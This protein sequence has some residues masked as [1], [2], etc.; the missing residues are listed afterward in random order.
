MGSKT[1]IGLV[2][3]FVASA[4]AALAAPVTKPDIAHTD[5]GHLSIQGPAYVGTTPGRPFLFLVP[6]TGKSFR[7]SVD[8]LPE[9][10]TLDSKSGIITG[11]VKT[12]GKTTAMLRL[13]GGNRWVKRTLTIVAGEHKL[14]QT[15]PMGWNSWNVWGCSV[16]D[17]KV[18]DAADW[19]VKSGLAA[20]GYQY[21]N[22]D[23]C[24]EGERDSAGNI[25]TNKKFPDMKAL[26][27]YVHSKGLKLGIYSSPGSKTCAG[28]EGS[29]QHEAQDAKTYAQWGIDYGVTNHVGRLPDSV[30]LG[31]IREAID[32]GITTLDTAPGYGDA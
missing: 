10:L 27:D 12:A 17:A 26:A 14:A 5:K 28:L 18:R 9:G 13:S 32:S 24:W 8:N 25:T 30:L 6:A 23:D 22:I 1:S 4:T 2:A 15:P 21:I 11:S 20:H 19:M 31:V 16:D 29:Y 7:Y 3:L